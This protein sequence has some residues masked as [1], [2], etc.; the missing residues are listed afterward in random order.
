MIRE[1]LEL[2]KS[3]PKTSEKPAQFA[4]MYMHQ[5]P[6]ETRA[7]LREV[8]KALGG[9]KS[10]Q[11]DKSEPTEYE[12]FCE[13]LRML[14]LPRDARPKSIKTIAHTAEA[15]DL[16]LVKLFVNNG[17]EL[18]EGFTGGSL[19]TFAARGRSR[20]VIKYL[21]EQGVSPSES[22]LMWIA[23]EVDKDLLEYIC[24]ASNITSEQLGVALEDAERYRTQNSK[25]ISLFKKAGKAIGVMT[26]LRE[27]DISPDDQTSLITDV[28]SYIKS[29]QLKQKVNDQISGGNLGGLHSNIS[30]TLNYSDMLTSSF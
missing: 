27:S 6:R 16:E 3:L 23:L 15:G 19:I 28:A 20:Q 25:S 30:N 26:G 11:F 22:D 9:D 13:K 17:A 29:G 2:A 18:Q 5:T 7:L 21:L 24:K 8:I 14:D 4:Q 12:V 1:L 10:T